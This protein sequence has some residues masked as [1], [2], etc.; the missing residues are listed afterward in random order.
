MPPV[1]PSFSECSGQ[2]TFC[3][4]AQR[5][6]EAWGARAV[7]K[8]SCRHLCLFLSFV[9]EVTIR[10]VILDARDPLPQRVWLRDVAESGR[11]G[12]VWGGG[13]ED[14]RGREGKG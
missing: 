6:V 8:C 4:A 2:G 14:G 5:P 11:D 10:S 3:W 12:G 9:R 13:Q 7:Q 1:P